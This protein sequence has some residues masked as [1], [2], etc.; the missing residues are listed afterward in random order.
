[1]LNILPEC[2]DP[3]HIQ[4]GYRVQSNINFPVPCGFRLGHSCYP[5][6]TL[7]Q[8]G[9]YWTCE[10]QNNWG[11]P[12]TCTYSMYTVYNFPIVHFKMLYVIEPDR[13]ISQ[14]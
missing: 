6:Y 8:Q 13:H 4:H 14:G 10:T 7:G 3:G 5:S 1:M 11:T 12:P 2:G 9:A